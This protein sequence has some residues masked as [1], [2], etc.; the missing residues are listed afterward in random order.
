MTR[1]LEYLLKKRENVFDKFQQLGNVQTRE[2][3]GTGLGLAIARGF[4]EAH[5]GKIWV[6]TG[7]KRKMVATFNSGSR[8]LA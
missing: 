6:D 1:D 7:E 8:F 3:G 4:V 5:K 2:Q